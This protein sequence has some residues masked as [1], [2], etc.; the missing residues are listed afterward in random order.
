MKKTVLLLS[1]FLTIFFLG[2]VIAVGTVVADGHLP[3]A[4][5]VDSQ[6][7]AS[8]QDAAYNQLIDQANQRLQEANK[9]IQDLKSQLNDPSAN[10]GPLTM[11]DVAKV[12]MASAGTGAPL[13]SVP[14]MVDY[15][16]QP[17]YE[18]IMTDGVTVY[19]DAASGMVTYNSLTGDASPAIN[20]DQAKQA[21]LDYMKKGKVKKVVRSKYNDMPAYK[22]S[23]SGGSVAYVDMRGQVLYVKLVKNVTVQ[24]PT[25]DTSTAAN[26]YTA[27]SYYSSSSSVGASSTTNSTSSSNNQSSG[28]NNNHGSND[29]EDS[30]D[31]GDD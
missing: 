15:M 8:D 17:A 13:A 24:N 7:V 21:A 29:H 30:H 20:S 28:G 9:I 18:V 31:G 23:F 5:N 14:D 2:I 6:T 3:A 27:P 4:A 12:A 11:Q 16:G 19:V 26:Y 25:P 10:H 1:I 22:V